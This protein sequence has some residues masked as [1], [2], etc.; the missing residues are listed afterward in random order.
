MRSFARD[1][2]SSRRAPPI[3]AS[4]PYWSSACFSAWVFITSVCT[5]APW[6][7]RADA[8]RDAFGIGVH[9]QVDAG[10]GRAAVAERDHLAELPAGVDVQQRDRRLARRERLQQQV[11]QHRAVLADR[12]QHHRIAEARPRPRAGCGCSRPRGDRG[13]WASRRA[14]SCCCGSAGKPRSLQEKCIHRVRVLSP[15]TSM[16]THQHQP[17]RR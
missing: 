11:Q 3:A 15:M 16:P 7:D 6:R 5:V 4:K 14:A 1:F 10:F 8:A 9:A 12:I 17:A 2:S 13:G